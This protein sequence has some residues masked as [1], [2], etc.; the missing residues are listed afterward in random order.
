MNSVISEKFHVVWF[1]DNGE[2]LKTVVISRGLKS[3]WSDQLYE[4]RFR[5]PFIGVESA[6]IV[7]VLPLGM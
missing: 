4:T 6:G 2:E 3:I 7:G 1:K 5:R